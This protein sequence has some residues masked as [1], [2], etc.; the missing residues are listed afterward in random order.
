MQI[1]LI[2]PAYRSAKFLE[3]NIGLLSKELNG[4]TSDYE[5]LIV[6]GGS[7]DGT[8]KVASAIAAGNRRVRY[9]QRKQRLGKGKAL[10]IGFGK[11]RGK[12]ATFMDADLEIS[13]K[14]L[15]LSIEKIKQGYDIAIVSQHHFKSNFQS[16]LLRKTLSKGYN[17]LVRTILG[18]KIKGHQGGLK[19]FRKEAI[20]E[21]LPFVRDQY[22]FWDTEVL[23]VGQWLG[24][25]IIEM[26]ITGGYGFGDSTVV[27]LKDCVS[28]FKS[29]LHLKRRRLTELSKLKP[30]KKTEKSFQT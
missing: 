19:C 25:R 23:M 21:I 14:Y 13:P 10:S 7:T 1:S 27:I 9:I 26:P 28:L 29:V 16:P 15:A 5:I 6:E 12:I 8:D 22:W 18:S 20:D 24:F 3:K 4:L 17:F 2:I 30:K 11:A